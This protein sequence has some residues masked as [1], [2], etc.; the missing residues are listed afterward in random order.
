MKSINRVATL[1]LLGLLTTISDHTL[2]RDGAAETGKAVLVTGASTGIGRRVAETLAAQGHFVYAG[3]RKQK[4]LDALDAIDNIQAVRLDVTIQEEIDAAVET[5]EDGGRGLYGLVNNA[6]VFIG[7]PLVD[8]PVEELHW[9]MDVNVYGVVRVT[10]AFA[11][12]IIEEKGRITTIGSISGILAGAFGG[13]YSMTKHAIEAF[14]DSLAA[15]ME[16]LGVQVSV[17]QPGNYD[18][19]IAETALSRMTSKLEAYT[20]AGSPFAEQ[21]DAWINRDWN[22]SAYKAP[23][24]VAENV[25]RALF[26]EFP[27][28]RY[29]TVP[30]EVEAGWTIGQMMTETAQ[31]NE[32]QA[33]RYTR[34]ELIAKLDLA[35]GDADADKLALRKKLDAFLAGADRRE[36]HESFWA[37]DLVYT[38]SQGTRTTKAD[39]L[40]GFDGGATGDE[41]DTP[42]YSAEDVEVQVYGGTAVVTF[43]LLATS[44]ASDDRA[45][46]TAYF[47]TGTFVKRNGIWQAV[48]WQA[49]ALPGA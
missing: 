21:F 5:V 18:S 33:Y 19:A 12:L 4:D 13:Q 1:I 40:A 35:L 32:G 34:D 43:K 10:Q 49:T 28:R 2:A 46:V 45:E 31:L 14:T 16:P 27:L 15:E 41:G 36:Q 11:P 47:N 23:D 7:G 3:A 42:T 8:V 44:P 26:D 37:D 30:N 38:S 6:G 29:M 25:T 17:V 48:A 20:K 24:E 9:M 22:R 39:I